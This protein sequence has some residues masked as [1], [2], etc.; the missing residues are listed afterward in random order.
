M[1]EHGYWSRG[2]RQRISRRRALR[3][4][5]L[6]ITGL[7]GAVLV[8][9]G[10]DD[11]P[12]ATATPADDNGGSS[13]PTAAPTEAPG[14]PVRGGVYRGGFTGPFAGVDPHNSVYGGSGIVPQVY[15]YLLRNE[16][17][18]RPDIGI[19]YD[20]ATSHELSPD[21]VTWTF[22][23]RDDAMIAPNSQGVP[24]RPL[25]AEDVVKSFDRIG[26][27]DAGANGFGFFNRWVESYSAPDA[28]TVQLVTRAPYAWVLDELGDALKG[29]IVPREWLASEDLK[30]TAVGA[31]PFILEELTEGERA[32]MVPNP[33][34]Y[35]SELPY[36]DEYRILT[37]SDLA[38]QRTA[39]TTR[40]LDTFSS[41]DITEADELVRTIDDV[42]LET[43]AGTGFKS[44]WMRTDAPPWDDERIRRGMSRAMNRQQYIDIIGKGQGEIIGIMS[45]ALAPYALD[46]DEVNE[47]QP[48][49]AAE[50]K[51]LFDAAGVSEISFTYPTSSNTSD[52]VNILVQQM[53]QIDITVSPDPQDAG[54]WVAG[55]FTSA[56]EASLSLNQSYKTPDFMLQ[57]YRSGGITG[58]NNYD[59]KYYSDA[60]D[61]AV[62]DAAGELD[63]PARIEKYRQAQRDIIATDPAIFHFYGQ[64]ENTLYY[65][66]IRNLSPGPGVMEN[67]LT[68]TYW[69][70]A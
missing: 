3:G 35:N 23:L 24:E 8:G 48:F 5:G 55:Y 28:T 70:D 20:L 60:T 40:Q 69:V 30:G 7:A 31:G 36:L 4:A 10:G 34:F 9:C 1:S 63:E 50:A 44:F 39:F 41:Q 16:S 22:T 66:D 29:V 2:A 49:D 26:S 61:A 12:T 56:L 46:A 65:N 25:D 64:L 67:A 38:T 6:G 15:N 33:N 62:D 68:R 53:E 59:T 37:F 57:F 51:K 52:F 14:T 42:V 11:D 58:N 19:V 47:L 45:Y 32:V 13:S 27:P 54:T 18:L 21:N 43:T 17:V